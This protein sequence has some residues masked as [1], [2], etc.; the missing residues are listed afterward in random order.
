MGKV[1]KVKGDHVGRGTL[2]PGKGGGENDTKKTKHRGEQLAK[3][4]PWGKE[5]EGSD[6]GGR[7]PTVGRQTKKKEE[8]YT[9]EPQVKLGFP[10]GGEIAGGSHFYGRTRE[11]RDKGG[12][13]GGG[14]QNPGGRTIAGGEDEGRPI[15]RKGGHNS[16]PSQEG[17]EVLKTKS[18]I[19]K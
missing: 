12:H 19:N 16:P 13:E 9:D 17:E 5:R 10:R 15:H 4:V 1:E 2:L 18:Q 11:E 3:P 7:N 8:N 6:R 14:R